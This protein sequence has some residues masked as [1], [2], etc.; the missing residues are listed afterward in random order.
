MMKII[1]IHDLTRHVLTQ[2]L[3]KTQFIEIYCPSPKSEAQLKRSAASIT[4]YG[5]LLPMLMLC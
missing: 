4:L 2:K 1:Y 3:N 5:L